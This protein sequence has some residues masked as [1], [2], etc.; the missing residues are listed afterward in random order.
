MKFLHSPNRDVFETVTEI[1]TSVDCTVQ[2]PIGDRRFR[3]VTAYTEHSFLLN[4]FRLGFR[5]DYFLKCLIRNAQ[6]N[7]VF[8][9]HLRFHDLR[10]TFNTRLMEAG[11]Q[12]E[13]RKSLMG[14]SSGKEINAVYT[15]VELPAKRE[16][17]SKL[18]SWIAMEKTR[19]EKKEKEEANARE[20]SSSNDGGDS[21]H[22]APES[23]NP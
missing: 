22:R 19:K 17:I 21:E 23:Q 7:I 2:K 11:V 6:V 13:I 1:H 18:E 16:A 12:Q 14:H 5:F 9:R 10:H 20:R 15:H 3:R 8:I 4:F